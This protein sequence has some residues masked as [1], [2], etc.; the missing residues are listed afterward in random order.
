MKDLHQTILQIMETETARIVD[1]EAKLAA[2]RV[3]DRVRGLTGSI[4]TK[5]TSTVHFDRIGSDLRII[6]KLPPP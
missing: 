5:V 2:K 4:A 3:E 6:V 1:E